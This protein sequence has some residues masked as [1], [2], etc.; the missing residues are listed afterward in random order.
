MKSLFELPDAPH[1]RGTGTGRLLRLAGFTLT[2]FACYFAAA[3]F[4]LSMLI[5][6]EKVAVFWPAA[7]V[8]A[9]L[10]LACGRQYLAP[11]AWAVVLATILAN[12]TSGAPF[13]LAIVFGIAN[14]V[15]SLF[16]ALSLERA[17]GRPTALDGMP[18]VLGFLLAAA[19]GSALSA[20]IGTAGILVFGSASA[21]FTEIW[22]AWFE[23]DAVGVITVAPL[24][25]GVIASL[26]QPLERLP[27]VEGLVALG[28]LMLGGTWIFLQPAVGGSAPLISPAVIIFPLLLWIA[29]RTPPAFSA[30][31][32]FA[33]AAIVAI[34]LTRGVGRFGDALIPLDDRVA[35]A[36]IAITAAT[37]CALVLSALFEERRLAELRLKERE[38]QLYRALAAG[39]ITAFEWI[40]S[41]SNAERLQIVGTPSLTTG[42]PRRIS[43]ETYL[44]AIVPEDR[45]RVVAT[46]KSLTP[47]TPEYTVTYR[48]RV[49]EDRTVWLEETGKMEFDEA[50]AMIRVSGLARDVTELMNAAGSQ[51][52]L[53]SELNHRVKNV[54][55]LITVVVDRSRE[56]Q[57]SVDAYATALRGR[58]G[59][60]TRTHTRLSSRGWSGVDLADIVTDELAPYSDPAAVRTGGPQVI[61]KPEAAQAM[62]LVLHELATN[63]AKFGALAARDGGTVQ[64]AWQVRGSERQPTSVQLLWQETVAV[65]LAEPTR[66]GYGT[67]MI[68]NL[69][70]YELGGTVE[71]KFQPVG[72]RCFISLPAARVLDDTH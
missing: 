62:T 34:T 26:R 23:S 47:A 27:A 49:S 64:V 3:R 28:I 24:V 4:G 50:G 17:F 59:A 11:T 55:N 51:R 71:L 66:E 69:L 52:R 61:L 39:R 6:E 32:S 2:A 68:R 8:A 42:T 36:Q 70:T 18:R 48:Y 29:A 37:F 56:R 7:G 54:L 43:R 57:D 65:P 9:G 35:A 30:A 46:L 22:L 5:P 60:M 31:A 33:V 25:M 20:F 14:A 44:A 12:V 19:A 10:M 13:M 15:E 67:S 63:A 1:P 41:G 72:V 38:G 45:D 58:I 21:T 40:T 53:I 16:I